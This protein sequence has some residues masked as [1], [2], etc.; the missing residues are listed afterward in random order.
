[1]KN[2]FGIPSLLLRWA[3]AIPYVWFV[4]DRLGILGGP[5]Q[6]HV[7]W[8]S[9]EKFMEFARQVMSFL[10]DAAVEPLAILASFGE[11][12]LGFLL[13]AGLFTRWAAL[14]SAGLS[15]LFAISMAISLGIESPLGYS[16]FTL[17]AGSLL[18]A[19]IPEYAFSVDALR[20]SKK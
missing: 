1:M 8:G 7:G 13:M 6:P 11:L 4:C 18:L 19:A 20:Q 15:F 14:G 9:W 10:P 17:S 12:V 16:V 2:N 5:G 3:I